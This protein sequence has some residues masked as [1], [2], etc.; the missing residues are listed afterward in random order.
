MKLRRKIASLLAFIMA[1]S[2]LASFSVL[3]DTMADTFVAPEA[4][5]ATWAGQIVTQNWS[6]PG[7]TRSA[8]PALLRWNVDGSGSVIAGGRLMD[9]LYTVGFVGQE[10]VLVAADVPGLPIGQG[11]T[12]PSGTHSLTWSLIGTR[13]AEVDIDPSTGAIEIDPFVAGVFLGDINLTIRVTQIIVGDPGEAD[14]VQIAE[15][16]FVLRLEGTPPPTNSIHYGFDATGPEIATYAR[17]VVR[18][19][20]IDIELSAGW[21][22][23]NTG[24][25]GAAY[26]VNWTASPNLAGLVI[27]PSEEITETTPGDNDGQSRGANATVVISSNSIPV[28]THE[29]TIRAQTGTGAGAT[30]AEMVL[31]LTIV[32][33]QPP[34]APEITVYPDDLVLRWPVTAG[35]E[36]TFTF[37]STGFPLPYWEVL[38][39]T[40][41]YPVFAL[42]AGPGLSS[43]LTVNLTE[44]GTRSFT[45]RSRNEYGNDT[46][47]IT[48]IVY[49]DEEF[50]PSPEQMVREQRP[51]LAIPTG[52]MFGFIGNTDARWTMFDRI[53]NIIGEMDDTIGGRPTHVAPELVIPASALNPAGGAIEI[54]LDGWGGNAFINA[55]ENAIG[56]RVLAYAGAAS[57]FGPGMG[58]LMTPQRLELLPRAEAAGF[59]RGVIGGN[60]VFFY[61]GLRVS[62]TINPEDTAYDQ[63][64]HLFNEL[65]LAIRFVADGSTA[66]AIIYYPPLSGVGVTSVLR[67][68]VIAEGTATNFTTEPTLRMVSGVTLATTPGLE[69]GVLR[70]VVGAAGVRF[71]ITNVRTGRNS[72]TLDQIRLVGAAGAQN[73]FIAN[74]QINLLLP[75]G[76]VWD[77]DA[78]V[79]F[80]TA[81]GE[82]IEG[83]VGQGAHVFIPSNAYN[84]G[85]ALAIPRDGQMAQSL[86]VI[87][88]GDIP[89]LRP[90]QA[91]TLFINGLTVRQAGHTPGQAIQEGDVYLTISSGSAGMSWGGT[92]AATNLYSGP[93]RTTGGWGTLA[94][95]ATAVRPAF[96]SIAPEYRLVARFADFGVTFARLPAANGGEISEIVAGWLPGGPGRAGP[97]VHE[98]ITGRRIFPATNVASRGNVASVRFE[99]IVPNSAWTAHSLTFT[100]VDEYGDPHPSVS[101]QNVHFT[102]SIQ[103]V[104]G[105]WSNVV[106]G[107]PSRAV[108][109]FFNRVNAPA[110]T[111]GTGASA[112]GLFGGASVT[113][114]PDGNTVTIANMRLAQQIWDEGR[115]RID[116]HFAL[117]ADVMYYGNV[118]IQV[119]DLGQAHG[120]AAFGTIEIDPVQVATVRRGIEVDFESTYV[121]VGFQTVNISDITIREMEVGDFR[122][123]TNIR[124]GL[125]EYMSGRPAGTSNVTFIP[126]GALQINNHIETG[127]AA[128]PQDRVNARLAPTGAVADQ[129]EV[130]IIQRTRGTEPSWIRLHSL[131]VRIIRDV[132]YGTYELVIRGSSVL[133]NENFENLNLHPGAAR[134][135]MLPIETGFARYGHGPFMEENFIVVETP[136]AGAG[137]FAMNTRITVPF[138]P[139]SVFTVNGEQL[140]FQDYHGNV[141]SSANVSAP[142][143]VNTV[144]V[145]T[146][147]LFVPL[148]PIIE[149]LGGTIDFHAGNLYEGIP[150]VLVGIVGENRAYF[151]VGVDS[152]RTSAAGM[153]IPMRTDGIIVMPFI[154]DGVVGNV[155][156][157]Y[158]P[159]RYIVN[160]LGLEYEVDTAGQQVIINPN[161]LVR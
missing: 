60:E 154:G 25:V 151:R 102:P 56:E 144:L 22:F 124:V 68:P 96:R 135:P 5:S 83:N 88:L 127:G 93:N 8:P 108:G 138:A 119:T 61:S 123:G 95:T 55:W 11:N 17:S 85:G 82:A 148:R 92:H 132:P 115:I 130:S 32:G 51:H 87:N 76:Y 121:Q 160:A 140:N 78:H 94:P 15:H 143:V 107:M 36:G 2:T 101:I 71:E 149:A 52:N 122:T 134:T 6:S 10:P 14:H 46:R 48:I 37:E 65:P 42:Q 146:G 147:R 145:P 33:V 137:N 54:S 120:G 117:T 105:T 99:E 67:F 31:T 89:P 50:E 152:Y 45:I 113:F 112:E 73:A 75:L 74:G 131:Q 158:I 116:A 9:P 150:H 26:N 19:A 111:G 3:A 128:R 28:G 43:V 100:V 142:T 79:T 114:G 58:T 40:P 63:F 125:G 110:P 84:Y 129:L 7:T 29:I 49:E 53:F 70:Y 161:A 118:Y 35:E 13:P 103:G 21:A 133:N 72:V 34:H 136:G 80:G 38:N 23:G 27:V 159:I 98:R 97:D 4:A 155:G 81:A 139:G 12:A 86:L 77:P 90:G 39:A 1:F 156:V 24:A 69:P 30:F 64:P 109:N 106:Q 57:L 104:S 20:N 126:I 141:I 44:P 41:G 47:R 153:D 59:S 157:T 16:P 91:N 18:P 66:R 62:G